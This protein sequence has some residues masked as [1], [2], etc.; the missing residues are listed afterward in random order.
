MKKHIVVVAVFSFFSIGCAGVTPKEAGPN[1]DAGY[2]AIDLQN[3]QGA[4]GPET[5]VADVVCN[6]IPITNVYGCQTADRL[7]APFFG[8]DPARI[9]L[10]LDANPVPATMWHLADDGHTL[11]IQHCV[12]TGLL[13]AFSLDCIDTDDDCHLTAR[14]CY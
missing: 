14:G 5:S 8:V 11:V 9:T 1:D 2:S 3:D 6:R 13:L 7:T 10:Y 4:V 12:D